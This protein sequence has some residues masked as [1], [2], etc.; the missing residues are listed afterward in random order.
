MGYGI[1][2]QLADPWGNLLR[3]IEPV[4]VPAA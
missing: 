4:A 3:I 2:C 1:D